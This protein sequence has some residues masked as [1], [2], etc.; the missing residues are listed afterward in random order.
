LQD[1]VSKISSAPPS[2]DARGPG[3][4]E[5]R[6]APRVR[7]EVEVSL[8]SESHFFVGLTGDLS[9][10]GLFVATWRKLP[11]GATLDVELA[12]PDGP[13]IARGTVRWL[14]DAGD[15]GAPGVGVAFESLSDADRARIESFCAARAPWYYEV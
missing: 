5:R 15:E 7:V 14:R 2:A 9:E 8:A 3:A 6:G 10:G 12:L 13:V 4:T 11:V 1:K